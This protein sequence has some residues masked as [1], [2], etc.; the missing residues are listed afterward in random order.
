MK[1]LSRKKAEN[2]SRG[3]Q[4]INGNSI[5]TTVSLFTAPVIRSWLPKAVENQNPGISEFSHWQFVTRFYGACHTPRVIR[6]RLWFLTNSGMVVVQ[7]RYNSEWQTDG[8]R[9]KS[10]TGLNGDSI[11]NIELLNC[12]DVELTHNTTTPNTELN[13]P[14]NFISLWLKSIQSKSFHSSN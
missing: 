4:R 8:N 14:I 5:P 9:Q 6:E 10:N 7:L 12:W 11:K 13:H 2:S 3:L 1:N